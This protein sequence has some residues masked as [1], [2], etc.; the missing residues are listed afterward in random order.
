[1]RVSLERMRLSYLFG[2]SSGKVSELR[3]V[4]RTIVI[5][6]SDRYQKLSLTYTKSNHIKSYNCCLADVES[7]GKRT[8]NS[9]SDG[10]S[11]SSNED[12]WE[13][14]HPSDIR[15]HCCPN[16]R[17]LLLPKQTLIHARYLTL[18]QDIPGAAHTPQGNP[19]GYRHPSEHQI[20]TVDVEIATSDN[21][22]IRGWLMRSDKNERILVYFH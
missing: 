1:M 14:G 11:S 12:L 20:E 4:M 15:H 22:R 19:A 18:H 16:C 17:H 6:C 10:N 2:Q 13:P 7:A 9:H 3:E 8:Q 21:V 5:Q